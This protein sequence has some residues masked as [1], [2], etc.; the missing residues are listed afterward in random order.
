MGFLP[1]PVETDNRSP[2]LDT[3]WVSPEASVLSSILN[4]SPIISSVFN[5]LRG[6]SLH[7]LYSEN[8]AFNTSNGQDSR[9]Y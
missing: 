4:G 9:P 6:F 1:W 8:S 3:L 2:T 5:F 7:N